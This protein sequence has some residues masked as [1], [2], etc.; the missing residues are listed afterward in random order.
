MDRPDGDDLVTL[1]RAAVIARLLAGAAHEVNNA[2]LVIG[3]T[4]ELLEDRVDSPEAVGKGLARIR[5]QTAK[6]AGAVSEVLSFARGAPDARG[7]VNLRETAAAAVGLRSYAIGRAGLT[8]DFAAP[9]AVAF[10][11]EGSRVL[12]QQAI[13]NLIANAEQ[14]LAGTRGGAIRVA[15]SE[16]DGF[17]DLRVSDT[18]GGV[19]E[20]E[21]AR[22]FEP[23]V[24][25]RGR[26]ESTGL[27][28]P[29]A[30]RIAE[31]HG[32]SLTLREA[33][34]GAEFVLTL[35]LVPKARA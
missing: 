33:S 8:I 16:R 23:F 1:N 34:T 19:P 5:A 3:G 2:L 14:A 11:V 18:G 31:M 13:L 21:R 22:I 35:P 12:L 24:T 26:D 9:E 20:A 10:I 15:L 29:A 25:T 4:A 30:R 17:A 7:S 27:G 28:L 6:A 32:G